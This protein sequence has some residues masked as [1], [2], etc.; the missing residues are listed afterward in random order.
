[1]RRFTVWL[2]THGSDLLFWGCTTLAVANAVSA[3]TGPAEMQ[4]QFFVMSV[5][6]GVT[7]LLLYVG[8]PEDT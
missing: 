1:M 8:K 3:V 2:S 4:G 5:A 7:A 6:F